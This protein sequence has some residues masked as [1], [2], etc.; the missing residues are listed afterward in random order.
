M[1]QEI[2]LAHAFTD[3]QKVFIERAA[4]GIEFHEAGRQAGYSESD[5][6]TAVWRLTQQPAII[7]AIQ[8]SV[9]RRLALGSGVALRVLNEFV[10][11]ETLDKRLRVVCAKTLLDRAGHIA[12]K[13]VA[14]SQNG[15]IP[16]NEMSMADLRQ[17]ADKLEGEI[18]GRAK[19]VSS[20]NAAPERAQTIEDIM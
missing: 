1:S 3:R 15:A 9:A 18:A 10:A 11:D 16:L 8:I 20:A 19:D 7:A 6:P 5:I 13:A 2:V 17:L 4:A 14:A 12:P